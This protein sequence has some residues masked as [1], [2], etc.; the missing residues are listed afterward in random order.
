VTVV[1]DVLVLLGVL[2][3]AASAGAALLRVIG[4]EPAAPDERLLPAV[5]AGVGMTS[6]VTL[7]LT[8]LAIVSPASLGIAWVAAL[9][10]GG[11]SAWAALRAV[12]RH[13][14]RRAWPVLVVCGL[15][16][17]AE[18]VAMLAPPIGGDQT[19]YQ[20]VYPRLYADAGALVATP[21]TFWGQQQ[22]LQ[23]FLFVA[24]F[25][26]RGED[27][28]ALLNGTTGVLAAVAVATLVRRHLAPRTGAVAGLLFFTL[29]M[30]WSQ[31]ARAGADLTVVLYG[32]LAM[33]AVLDWAS[34]ARTADLRRAAL[35]AGFAGGTKV[36]G[37]VVPALVGLVV[38]GVLAVRRLHLARTFGLALVFGVVVLA[39]ALPFYVRNTVETGNPMYPFGYGV[40]GGPH[41]SP[42]AAA[43]LDLYYQQYQTLHASRR[44]AVPYLGLVTL[45]FP[46]DLTM[47]PESFENT[48]RSAYD[49]SPFVLAFLPAVLL[50]RRQ[51][52]AAWI[53]AGVGM[54]YVAVIAGGA[55][56]HP[57][58]VLTGV[59]LCLAAAVA[60]CQALCGERG[61]R[62]VA[63]FTVAGNLAL[64]ATLM[65]PAW[66]DQLRV[67]LGALDDESYLRRHSDRFVFWERA[68][69][70]IP[71][72]GRVAVLAKIPH[73][74]D[75]H[76]PFVLLSF[77]EQGLLDYR[78]ADS[79]EDVARA[80]A[81]L[82]A[83]HVAIDVA[84][85]DEQGD[86]FETRVERLWR[87]FAA[88]QG[89]PLVEE[90]G[91]ALYAL[92]PPPNGQE[93]QQRDD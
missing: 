9:G 38:L 41:W 8:A 74:Y 18:T 59:V 70:A 56:A 30:T 40:F 14:I 93:A 79:P 21:W 63:A 34:G 26:L 17:A 71:P 19:K 90:R 58:Y 11:R 83:T 78:T 75:I 42:E 12:D 52:R 2:V 89:A 37:L 88:T 92:A 50:V 82:E 48:A 35:M 24:G 7:A 31:M 33:T 73:P 22:F 84:A 4:A 72:D 54:A 10:A 44:E 53:V 80:L 87:A 28:A 76:R 85:L 64:T 43:Y 47:Y 60:G 81:D 91:W 27:L 68:N 65:R 46:W 6:L 51:R 29:P 5:A 15:V 32:A 86:P 16:L 69:A 25:T 55:W 77:L 1:L 13:R 36:M 45:R 61:L 23:N 3:G 39:A 62:L 57:R 20:L 67:A 66:P 49:V